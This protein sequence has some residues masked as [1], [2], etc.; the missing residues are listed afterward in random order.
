MADRAILIVEDD[1][2]VRRSLAAALEP[3]GI[4]VILAEDGIEALERLRTGPPPSV[5]LLDLRLP[6]LAGEEVL[7]AMRADPRFEH[8]PV[9]T[10]TAGVDGTPDHEVIARLRKP[11][12]VADLLEIV[13]SLFEASAA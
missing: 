12:D 1:A 8:V 5:V 7:S 6:R 2:D 10:M 3:H 9:I 4:R 13:L 11:F